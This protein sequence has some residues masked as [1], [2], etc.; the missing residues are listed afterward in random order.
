MIQGFQLDIDNDCKA[1]AGAG[2]CE[3]FVATKEMN[4]QY[5][6][7]TKNLKNNEKCTISI[8]A[9][10]NVARVILGSKFDEDLGVLVPGYVIGQPITVPQGEKREITIYNGKEEGAL[11]FKLSFSGANTLT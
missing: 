7:S 9:T 11:F 10:E 3:D 8:D 6:N 4:G 5:I 1:E 2:K